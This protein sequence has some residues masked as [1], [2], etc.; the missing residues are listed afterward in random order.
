MVYLAAMIEASAT[1]H[2][3]AEKSLDMLLLWVD[4]AELE[5]KNKYN[6][7]SADTRLTHLHWTAL[8]N[9]LLG[10]QSSGVTGIEENVQIHQFGMKVSC[11]HAESNIDIQ[12]TTCSLHH[13]LA[14]TISTLS[15]LHTLPS[16]RDK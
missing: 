1:S 2:V 4:E 14:A 16:Y 5:E 11:E 6:L 3:A 15:T 7:L 10:L 8:V 13:Q 12:H 9:S